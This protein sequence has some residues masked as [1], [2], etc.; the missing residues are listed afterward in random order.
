MERE[1]RVGIRSPGQLHVNMLTNHN[2]S[3]LLKEAATVAVICSWRPAVVRGALTV[4]ARGRERG[5]ERRRAAFR[6]H[7]HLNVGLRVLVSGYPE[8]WKDFMLWEHLDDGKMSTFR[9]VS[10]V[11]SNTVSIPGQSSDLP[12]QR[13]M[14]GRRQELML[15]G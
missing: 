13:S 1:E 9:S 15:A 14:T 10:G 11:V 5:R 12:S 4:A 6:S 8:A 7:P 2:R 3:T